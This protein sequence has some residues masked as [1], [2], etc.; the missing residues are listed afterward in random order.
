MTT[1][2]L[3][4]LAD[5]TRATPAELVGLAVLLAGAVATTLVLWWRAPAAVPVDVGPGDP[6]TSAAVPVGEVT[7]HVSGAVRSPGVRSLADGSRVADAL[8]A[9]GG[10]TGEADLH[11]LNLA[12]PLRDGEQVVVPVVGAGAVASADGVTADGRVDLNRADA[13]EL[14]TLPG[15]GPVLAA[16]IVAWRD[17]HGPFTDVGQL[18]EVAGIGEKSFQALVDRVVVR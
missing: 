18:R 9:A 15:V 8:A 12:R 11:A 17:Q 7:V 14:E 5:A 3:R 13:G 10:A 1:A 16:R 4:R 2:A 6:A